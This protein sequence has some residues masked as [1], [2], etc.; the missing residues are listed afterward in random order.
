MSHK[1]TCVSRE[2]GGET[3][4]DDVIKDE[5]EEAGQVME[6]VDSPPCTPQNVP[7]GLTP[8]GANNMKRKAMTQTTK[9]AHDRAM[10]TKRQQK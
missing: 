3:H 5:D 10:N 7:R 4:V 1:N 9:E 2:W 6:M 8:R